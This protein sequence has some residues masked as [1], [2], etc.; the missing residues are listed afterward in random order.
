MTENISK[1]ITHD[2]YACHC[3]G[4]LPPDLYT[5]IAYKKFFS[6]FDS[7][8]ESWGKPIRV[9]GF[10]CWDRNAA[11]GGGPQSVHLFGLALDCD[12]KDVDE[13]LRLESHILE[14]APYLR[15]GVYTVSGTFIHIDSGYSINPRAV[16]EWRRG[17]RWTG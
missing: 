11:V 7:L 4:S 8:R 6:I 14:R 17:A 10:R 1:Y 12:C 13:T 2:E 5:S 3:C 15:I 9:S 16:H